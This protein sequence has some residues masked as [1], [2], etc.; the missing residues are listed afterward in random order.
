MSG[1]YLFEVFTAID[2]RIIL[3]AEEAVTAKGKTVSPAKF[4][5]IVLIA[6]VLSLLLAACGYIA[7]C[8]TMSYREPQENDANNYYINQRNTNGVYVEV[9]HG[10]CALALHFVTKE[11]GN[12]NGFSI[13]E[14]NIPG[15]TCVSTSSLWGFFNVFDDE[16]FIKY[17]VCMAVEALHK[18]GM[19][20]AEAEA[21]YTN[22]SFV[23]SD[24]QEED[25]IHVVLYDSPY[26]A[27]YDLILGWPEGTATV[28]REDEFGKYQR[29]ELIVDKKWDSGRHEIFK[30]LFLFQPEGQYL[31]QLSAYDQDY[32]FEELELVAESLDVVKTD[33]EYDLRNGRMN[34]SVADHGAG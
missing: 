29:L 16:D 13:D 6:A 23:R 18:A 26:L 14:E 28:E 33:L 4:G 34:F 11:T 31:L 27:Q 24:A 3:S 20:K 8:A 22:A 21:L 12:V 1:Q 10:D 2:D 7:L 9:N 5:R 15:F 30:H 19:T 17:P 25:E 32:T